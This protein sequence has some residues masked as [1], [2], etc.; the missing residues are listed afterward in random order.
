MFMKM[1]GKKKRY[2]RRFKTEKTS[3]FISYFLEML[4]TF[5]KWLFVVVMVWYTMWVRIALM[6]GVLDISLCGKVCQ[7]TCDRSVLLSGYS[8]FLHH[9]T[10]ILLKVALNT[11]ILTVVNHSN[12]KQRR[13][14]TIINDIHLSSIWLNF[15]V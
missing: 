7:V 10:K 12:N 3:C 13:T 5:V 2:A 15:S 8:S 14:K 9:I 11:I 6:V 1:L 4:Y